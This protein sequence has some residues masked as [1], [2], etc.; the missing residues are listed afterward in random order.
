MVFRKVKEGINIA[1]S[2]PLI[3]GSVAVGLGF[4]VLK[5]MGQDVYYIT[6]LCVFLRANS[7]QAHQASSQFKTLSFTSYYLLLQSL[8]SKADIRVKKLRQSIDRLKAESELERGA[9]VAEE[10]LIH[11]RTK[12]RQA[13]KQIQSVIHSAYKIERQAAGLKDILGELPRSEAS[14]FRSQVSNLASEAKRERNTLAE[15]VSKI[16]D[17]GIEVRGFSCLC[18]IVACGRIHRSRFP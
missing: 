12:L 13:G 6:R 18:Y 9:S 17:H 8:L 15:E 14:Q 10:E 5:S 11:G 1:A 16:S 7:G 3:T 4:L 2:Y